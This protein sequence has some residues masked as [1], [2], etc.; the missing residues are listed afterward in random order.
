MI[1]QN[2]SDMATP[3]AAT[4]NSPMADFKSP[5]GITGF[6]KAM[7][8]AV[9]LLLFVN[10]Y[11]TWNDFQYLQSVSNSADYRSGQ[12]IELDIP[13][14]GPRALTVLLYAVTY[15]TAW[16]TFL[17][18]VYRMNKNTHAFG[19]VELTYTPGWAVGWFFI[20]IAN[21]IKPYF[22]VQ[23]IYKASRHPVQWRQVSANMLIAAWWICWLAGSLL[24]GPSKAHGDSTMLLPMLTFQ[25]IHLAAMA[26]FI[27]SLGLEFL[28]I[29]EI[30]DLQNAL[31]RYLS[32]NPDKHPS[33]AACQNQGMENSP[34]PSCRKETEQ[35]SL[36]QR[37]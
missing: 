29:T 21:L 32:E 35:T 7:L 27:V 37:V 14:S 28:I 12:V 17:V 16:I 33:A 13:F 34:V 19:G 10:F 4:L 18:W 5:T 30:A 26:V 8:I 6:L 11:H 15:L 25:K 9:I 22:V 1:Y 36:Y 20:P 2:S 23:E 31:F 3:S 24:G